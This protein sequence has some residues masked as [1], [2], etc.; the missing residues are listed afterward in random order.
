MFSRLKKVVWFVIMC[1]IDVGL[2][3]VC[4]RI[5][6][7]VV[8]CCVVEIC[9]LIGIIVDI[10]VLGDFLDKVVIEWYYKY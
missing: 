8:V 9:K 4:G 6:V 2:Y 3:G 5:V 7:G 10:F 1:L